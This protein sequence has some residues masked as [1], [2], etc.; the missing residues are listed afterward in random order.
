MTFHINI[1]KTLAA[2]FTAITLCSVLISA[3]ANDSNGK[4]PPQTI[5]DLRYGESLFNFY[6]S[7]YFSALTNIMVA[8]AK[9]PITNQGDEPELLK[10]G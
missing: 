9:K 6:Q 8:D 3:S 7:K 2:S 1:T 4:L 5:K 10:G